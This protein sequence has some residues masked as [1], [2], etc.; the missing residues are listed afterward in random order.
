MEI[1]YDWAS[2]DPKDLSV[3][4]IQNIVDEQKRQSMVDI[5]QYDGLRYG[6]AITYGQ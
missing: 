4:V 5:L 1:G 2:E 3:K 6:V